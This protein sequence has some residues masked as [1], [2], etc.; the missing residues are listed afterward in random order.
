ME[1]DRRIYV[2]GVT[3]H[4]FMVSFYGSGSFSSC[5]PH[6]IVMVVLSAYSP[7]Q[8]GDFS[9]YI[10][11]IMRKMHNKYFTHSYQNFI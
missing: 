6:I 8:D 4:W 3:R 7:Y 5:L 11:D 9:I 2:L 1:K 10:L